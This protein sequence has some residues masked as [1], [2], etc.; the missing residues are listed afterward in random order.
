MTNRTSQPLAAWF[1]LGD[2]ALTAA[3][4][5]AAYW[6]RF[7]ADLIPVYRPVPEFGQYVANL[8][9]V[10]LLT[11]VS[12]RV[13]GM[14]EV[15]R[16]R[17]FREELAAV[18]RGVGLMALAVMATSFVRQAQY[19]SRAVMTRRVRSRPS[20]GCGGRRGRRCGRCGS[21]G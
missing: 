8:P 11:F 5:L 15:H 21:A 4:W 16:L 1:L 13:A 20:S 7:R 17:R 2:L 9:L 3:A 14:Y 19:E 18:G 10:V 6:L 12:Y